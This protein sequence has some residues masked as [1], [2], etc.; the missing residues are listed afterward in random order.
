MS[1]TQV[2]KGC[3]ASVRVSEA[4]IKRIVED[5]IQDESSL[6]VSQDQYDARLAICRACDYLDYGTTCRHC[7]C[8]VVVR[9]WMA[10]K[11][12]PKPGQAEW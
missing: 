10:D 12:C 11:G 9:A 1:E 3:R 4:E 5:V 7:G 2:C 6:L 8:L